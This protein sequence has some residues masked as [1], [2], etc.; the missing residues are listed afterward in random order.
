MISNCR[1]VT[2]SCDVSAEAPAQQDGPSSGTKSADSETFGV[3]YTTLQSYCVSINDEEKESDA[4]SCL[5]SFIQIQW[6]WLAYKYSHIQ[7]VD[8]LSLFF[9]ASLHHKHKYAVLH[10]QWSWFDSRIRFSFRCNQIH[11]WLLVSERRRDNREMQNMLHV[12][13]GFRRSRCSCPRLKHKR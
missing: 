9:P 8:T 11:F 6:K 2:A 4:L 1:D 13:V 7:T 12:C 10:D 3:Q 5:T